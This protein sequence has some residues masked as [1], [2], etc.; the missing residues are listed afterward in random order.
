MHL[1]KSPL[2]YTGNKFRILEKISKYF[3]KKINFMI[4]LFCGGATVG[5]NTNA[6]KIIF[7]DSNKYIVNLLIFLSKQKFEDFIEKCSSI[8][9]HY[10]LSFSYK[11]GYQCY[12]ENYNMDNNGLKSYNS[13]GY[14]KMRSDYNQLNDKNTDDANT[15]LYLLMIY[16]FNNDIRFNSDGNFNLPVGKTD[17]NKN[18]IKKISDYIERVNNIKTE[19]ICM[20]FNNNEFNDI[21]KEVDFVYMDPPYLL[22][23]AFYNTSWDID[24]EYK[25]LDFIDKLLEKKINFALSNVIR[26]VGKTNEPLSYWCYKNRSK[27]NIYNIDYHYKASSYNKNNR[28]S[29]E[30]EILIVNKEY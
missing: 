4:D 7:V 27:I 24:K 11:N 21:L 23:N 3:P 14:Y 8:I 12:R 10:G 30:E 9:E 1:I 25:L 28:N 19:F 13:V 29:K 26:K 17:L 22:G 2:N 16:G 18:N 5:L 15:L 20:D 6:N